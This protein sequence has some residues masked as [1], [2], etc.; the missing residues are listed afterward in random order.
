M[1][2]GALAGGALAGAYST[3]LLTGT[4]VPRAR[5]V[6]VALCGAAVAVGWVR[7]DPS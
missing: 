7:G 4:L 6:V 5:A 2:G 3:T 1:A